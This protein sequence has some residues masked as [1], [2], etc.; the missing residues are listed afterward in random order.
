MLNKVFIRHRISH[1]DLTLDEFTVPFKGRHAARCY[2]PSK[3]NRYHLKG[4]SL[5][6]ARTGY[7]LSFLMY[8]GRDEKRPDG[9]CATQWPA[10]FLIGECAKLH[11]AGYHLWADNWFTG[12]QTIQSCL[13]FGVGYTGTAKANRLG[14]AWPKAQKKEM[15]GKDRG[16]YQAKQTTLDTHLVTAI[17]WK[18]SKVVSML[19]THDSKIGKVTRNSQNKKKTQT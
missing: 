12:L 15:V 19:T 13:Q 6:E 4:Y 3:P 7:C 16:T 2:N 8:Q 18:D 14:K 17:Q 9:V 10:L 11:H 1:H 5:N